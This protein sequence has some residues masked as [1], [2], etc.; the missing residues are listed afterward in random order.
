MVS[1]RVKTDNYTKRLT[2][3]RPEYQIADGDFFDKTCLNLGRIVPV[4]GLCENLNIKT[5]RKSV[6]NAIED[7]G[8]EIRNV[9]PEN[10]RKN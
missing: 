10:I 5:L 9:I 6:S 2:I 4:Y 3:T 1:G 7:Y 8:K